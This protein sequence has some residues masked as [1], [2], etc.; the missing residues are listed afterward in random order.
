[1]KHTYHFIKIT[2]VL[3]LIGLNPAEFIKI[4]IHG[5]KKFNYSFYPRG[6]MTINPSKNR[7]G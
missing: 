7:V 3:A 6:K 1:M 5:S 2:S 4:G